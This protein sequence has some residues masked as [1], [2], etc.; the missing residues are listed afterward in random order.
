MICRNYPTRERAGIRAAVGVPMA[1]G[2]AEVRVL[3]KLLRGD[4]VEQAGAAR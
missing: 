1:A 4:P 2:G 3:L